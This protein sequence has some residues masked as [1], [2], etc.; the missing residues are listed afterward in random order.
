[1]II[2]GTPASKGIVKGVVKKY[3]SLKEYKETDILVANFTSPEMSIN[4]AKVSAVLTKFGGVL[5]HAAIFCRELGIPCIVGIG[6]EIDNLR[7][8]DIITIDGSTG[9]IEIN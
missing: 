9:K 8:G 5:S 6:E 2:K 7:D 3:S 1:M 4:I